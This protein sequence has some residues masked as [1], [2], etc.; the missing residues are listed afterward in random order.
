MGLGRIVRP[1]LLIG[2]IVCALGLSAASASADTCSPT[3]CT[4][5]GATPLGTGADGWSVSTNWSGATGPAAGTVG[6]LDFASLAGC[7][8]SVDVCG[9]S[10]NDITGGV[11]DAG[12]LV[13][14]TS[15]G[16]YTVGGNAITLEGGGVSLSGAGEA[17][18][19]LPITFGTNQ[20]WPVDTGILN[21]TGAINSPGESLAV[22]LT[23]G[24]TFETNTDL[25]VPGGLTFD[26]AG[27]V[28]PGTSL[29]GMNGDPVTVSAGAD[30]VADANLSTGALATA[31]ATLTLGQTAP[32]TLTANGNVGL[33]S[34]TT[35]REIVNSPASQSEIQASGA[36]DVGGTLSLSQPSG[37][38]TS[39]NPGDAYTL[40]SASGTLTGTFSNA[41][42]GGLVAVTC[43]GSEAQWVQIDYTSSAVIAT[44]VP[45][46][47]TTPSISGTDQDGQ[48]LTADPGVWSGT[49]PDTYA[50]Q[51]Y[52]CPSADAG[53]TA[54]LPDCTAISGATS[55]T[56]AL[57]SADVGKSVLVVV[58]ATQGTLTSAPAESQA[59]PQV[60]ALRPSNA[61]GT[62][63]PSISGTAKDGQTLTATTGTWTGSTPITYSYQWLSCNGT[64]SPV[65]TNAN[66]YTLNSSDVGNTIEV[67]VT[68]D[69]TSLPG[70]GTSNATSQPT[71]TVQA[72]PPSN[73]GG[74]NLPSI[75]GTLKDGQTLT[76]TT[77]TWNG[78]PPIH[79]RYQWIECN[80]SGSSCS[81][82][83]G[84]T[85][86]TYTLVSSD[87][88][89]TLE[90]TVT[91]DNRALPGGGT[92]SAT[93]ATT[94]T[95]QYAIPTNLSP[96]TTAGV[97][98]P[99]Q[100]LNESH[101]SWNH[102]PDSYHYQWYEC[103]PS[104][105]NCTAIGGAT[106][107]SYTLVGSAV[108]H[109]IEVAEA[110]GNSAGF[111]SPIF[112]A[113]TGLVAPAAPRKAYAAVTGT[114]ASDS[115][116]AS[117]V[118]AG[119]SVGGSGFGSFT[120]SGYGRDP[121]HRLAN[122]TGRFIGLQFAPG[123]RFSSVKLTDCNL[124]RGDSLVYWT[125]S[126][127]KPL[128]QRYAPS[129][130]PCVTIT[131]SPTSRPSLA[132]RGVIILGARRQEVLGPNWFGPQPLG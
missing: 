49:G 63:A 64:C 128:S 71:G 98:R 110:A 88:N 16:D 104:G 116:S 59:T 26:G 95:I 21:L 35:L 52:D 93:S 97:L 112:S 86:S 119:S 90:V 44:A 12:G 111:A 56:Y 96:P 120:F 65:G 123:S 50:Y 100:T 107:P 9:Q 66:T 70:G 58:T 78:S 27:T 25:E 118:L 127:W 45:D 60:Q 113:P 6:S 106:H 117:A 115:G 51:W 53:K 48:T 105:T 37:S 130:P 67:T 5:T 132:T 92:S 101:G 82:L 74:A 22:D 129:H 77:G 124:N 81:N 4:W 125:G 72:L 84:Q 33:D 13:F 32:V 36:V 39:L 102:L 76:A 3:A 10:S 83:T 85:S 55:A 29:N 18:V 103:S 80:S 41:P 2:A 7:D 1:G 46:N 17:T 43:T 14:D 28:S 94:R 19:G 54:A 75:T 31:G 15:R 38:C 57:T 73:S 131:L 91:A 109:T 122:S 8:G 87:V 68:A 40:V 62:D 99:G 121:V 24:A 108:G 20:T 11:V 42:E 23:N 79:Y 114:S 69:N 126:R 89:H 47:T 30:L 61:G 34:S